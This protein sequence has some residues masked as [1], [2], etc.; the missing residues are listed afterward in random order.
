MT[1][2]SVAVTRPSEIK[3]GTVYTVTWRDG[4][5][6]KTI[7]RFTPPSGQRDGVDAPGPMDS[8]SWL[9]IGVR[10]LKFREHLDQQVGGTAAKLEFSPW[11][12]LGNIT[13]RFVETFG[14]PGRIGFDPEAIIKD[15]T[16][17]VVIG[18]EF[19]GC[20]AVLESSTKAGAD[21]IV[22]PLPIGDGWIGLVAR[23]EPVERVL[24]IPARSAAVL[25]AAMS[26][27]PR[28]RSRTD[29]LLTLAEHAYAAHPSFTALLSQRKAS[30]G[31]PELEA[32]VR[33]LGELLELDA[34]YPAPSLFAFAEV[35][36]KAALAVSAPVLDLH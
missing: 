23:A 28:A 36:G 27:S 31:V 26:G 5:D 12:D 17:T 14:F 8:P 35:N 15:T 7:A 22:K 9:M 16:A 3:K 10:L 13:E 25:V 19:G 24:A 2:A 33:R 21:V 32:R 6:A 4:T 34:A 18:P 30:T 29:A 1:P 11:T 20:V